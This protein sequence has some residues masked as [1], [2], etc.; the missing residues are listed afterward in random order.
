MQCHELQPLESA[1]G[2][3]RGINW[4]GIE[5]L[6]WLWGVCLCC[7]SSADLLTGTMMYF[8]NI[9]CQ[10]FI[11]NVFAFRISRSWATACARNIIDIQNGCLLIPKTISPTFLR[12]GRWGEVQKILKWLE[13]CSERFTQRNCIW[14]MTILSRTTMLRMRRGMLI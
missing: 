9:R 10:F 13:H 6:H 1:R 7:T 5:P 8:S 11:I 4:P 2:W 3:N 12:Y 14:E